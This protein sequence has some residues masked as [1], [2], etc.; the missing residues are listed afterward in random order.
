MAKKHPDTDDQIPDWLRQ[1]A[2]VAAIVAGLFGLLTTLITVVV[3]I[4]FG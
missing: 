2:V 1:P 3:P 4:I